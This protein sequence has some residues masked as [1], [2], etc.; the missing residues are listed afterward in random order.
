MVTADTKITPRHSSSSTVPW[1]SLMVFIA[2][3]N[4]NKSIQFHSAFHINHTTVPSCI[5]MTPYDCRDTR[6]DI[7]EYLFCT[8]KRYTRPIHCTK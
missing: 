4:Q 7:V 5:H 6:N 8:F 3:T 2:T 1:A